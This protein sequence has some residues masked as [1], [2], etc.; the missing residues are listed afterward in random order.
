M[1]VII[2]LAMVLLVASA[3][4]AVTGSTAR[5]G[6]HGKRARGRGANRKRADAAR[7]AG[8]DGSWPASGPFQVGEAARP[9]PP[10]ARPAPPAAGDLRAGQQALPDP[11]G[12]LARR[13]LADR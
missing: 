6:R 11:I 5:G 1:A 7:L 13:R 12:P 4:L 8:P 3:A 10:A 9:A 2:T